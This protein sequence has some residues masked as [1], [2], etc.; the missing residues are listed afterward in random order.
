MSP[1]C[2]TRRSP[3]AISSSARPGDSNNIVELPL[4]NVTGASVDLD[5]RQATV[6]SVLA[7]G[8]KTFFEPRQE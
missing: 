7:V 5:S 3:C 2:R 8:A 4:F 6:G 1:P